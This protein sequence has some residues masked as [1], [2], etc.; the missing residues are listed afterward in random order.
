MSK[1]HK[2]RESLAVGSA[3]E[4]L[5]CK[6]RPEWERLDGRKH[7]FVNKLTGDTLELKT[8]TYDMKQTRNF[9]IERYGHLEK[10]KPGGPWQAQV[11]GSTFWSYLFVQNMTLF[12]WQTSQLV[13]LLDSMKL[14]RPSYIYNPGYVTLGYKIERGLLMPIGTESKL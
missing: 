13:A 9:F 11:N 1:V 7:D 12:T 6:Y 8:D 14:P 2:F 10:L 3:G 4:A 5:F